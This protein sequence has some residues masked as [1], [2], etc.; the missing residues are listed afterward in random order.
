VAD[1]NINASRVSTRD[2]VADDLPRVTEIYNHYVLTSHATFDVDPWT[3]DQRREWMSHYAPR[4]RHRLIVAER[5]GRIAGYASSSVYRAK[6]A[7]ETSVETSVYLAP[8][9]RGRGLGTA[10]YRAL[11]DALAREDVHRAYAGIA[12][13]NDA[14]VALHERFGFSRVAYFSEQGRKFGRWWDV[15]WYE[16]AL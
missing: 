5:D 13:P 9:E 12:L 8:D 4:G 7:Y 1:T 10:L 3:V 14:S 15:A 6:R 16:K 2:A 11:F